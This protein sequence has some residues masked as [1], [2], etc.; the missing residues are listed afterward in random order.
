MTSI[1]SEQLDL[2]MSAGQAWL[3]TA[4]F[5]VAVLVG[6]V[7]VFPRLVYDRFI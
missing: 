6:G 7:L 3:L 4:G 2:S 5:A 1:K